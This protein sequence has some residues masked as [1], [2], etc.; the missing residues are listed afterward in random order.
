MSQSH[1]LNAPQLLELMEKKRYGVEYQP[2]ISTITGDTFAYECLSRFFNA[3]GNTIRPDLVYA[4][5]IGWIL[6]NKTIEN[7][8]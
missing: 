7:M 8:L 1:Y 6:R 5:F 3:Q 4:S 2:I